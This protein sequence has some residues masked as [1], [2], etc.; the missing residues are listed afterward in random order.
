M[1]ID[2][3]KYKAKLEKE[4]ALL[5]GEMKGIARK[6]PSNP[7]DWEAV[8]TEIDSDHADVNDVAD[9]MESYGENQAVLSKL[10]AQFNDIKIALE[11]IKKGTYGKCEVGGEDI[12]ENRLE[13][14]P[15]ARTCI[16]H[17]K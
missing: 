5:E 6:N 2:T 10:E 17:S 8:E 4:L 12:P 3:K 16:E 15:S 1:V 14:N 11:K 13:A 7:N 9:N